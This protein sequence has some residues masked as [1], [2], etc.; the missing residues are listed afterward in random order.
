[1]ILRA[2]GKDIAFQRIQQ[3]GA[4]QMIPRQLKSS[5]RADLRRGWKPRPVVNRAPGRV[6]GRQPPSQ[7]QLRACFSRDDL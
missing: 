6:L 7:N 4:R 3:C 5:F 1:M 2:D